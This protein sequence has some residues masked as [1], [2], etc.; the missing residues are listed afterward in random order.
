[1]NNKSAAGADG[2]LS[3]TPIILFS[4][5][6]SFPDVSDSYDYTVFSKKQ[7]HFYSAPVAQ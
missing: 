3:P 5:I 2:N 7:K 4:I 6:K 1:M